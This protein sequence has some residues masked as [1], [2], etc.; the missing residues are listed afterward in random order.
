MIIVNA[1]DVEPWHNDGS[2]VCVTV[3]ALDIKEF[4]VRMLADKLSARIRELVLE[5]LESITDEDNNARSGVATYS[6]ELL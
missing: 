3:D 1:T 6:N 5:E 2:K 4:A